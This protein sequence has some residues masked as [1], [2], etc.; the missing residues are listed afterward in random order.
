MRKLFAIV[1]LLCA[2]AGSGLSQSRSFVG[3]IMDSQCAAMHSHSRMMQGMNAKDA[4]ECT[5]KCIHQMKGKYA[6]FDASSNTPYQLDNQ[7]KAAAF[8]GQKVNVKGTYDAASK[9]I[10]V[11]SI[12]AQ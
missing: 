7:E 4:K 2:G 1:S 3:E 8:A 9:T 6:L 10:H 5:E 11:E 12:E